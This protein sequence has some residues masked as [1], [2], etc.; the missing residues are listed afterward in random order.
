MK[1]TIL[2]AVMA[3]SIFLSC[4]K[5]NTADD[6]TTITASTT[7]AAVGQTVAL[8]VTT[9]SNAVSWTVT[10]TAAATT[11]YT[12]TTSKSNTVSFAQ[13]GFYTVGVR[14]RHI[15][16]DS[17]RHQNLDSCWHHGGGDGGHCVHG[18]DSASVVISVK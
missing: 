17:T 7:Q 8:T 4:S 2:S 18:L 14:A 15:E 12:I 3:A 5:S 10:P 11:Q 6:A 16:Y 9:P 13:P 1:R